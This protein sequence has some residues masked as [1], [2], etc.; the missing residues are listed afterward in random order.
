MPHA[1]GIDCF[2]TTI[3]EHRSC[4]RVDSLEFQE[5]AL[6]GIQRVVLV[7]ADGGG[8]RLVQVL[9]LKLQRPNTVVSMLL[10]RKGL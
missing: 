7:C 2:S 5:V 10:T 1:P 9:R 4:L 3:P 8:Q 6:Q